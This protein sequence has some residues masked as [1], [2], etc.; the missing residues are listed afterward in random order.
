MTVQALVAACCVAA[1]AACLALAQESCAPRAAT[2]GALSASAGSATA[3]LRGARSGELSITVWYPG[4]PAALERPVVIGSEQQPMFVAGTVA[5]GAAWE[6]GDARPLLVVSHGFGGSARQLT[7][8]GSALARQ[9]YVVAAVDHPGSNGNE[10]M[11]PEGVYAPWERARDLSRAID[12]LLAHPDV[13]PRLDSQRI[14]VAGFSLGGWTA[15]LLAGARPDFDRL[16]AFC[17]GPARDN[18]CDPQHE[19][20]IDIFQQPQWLAQPHMRPLAAGAGASHRDPRVRGVLLIAPALGQALQPDSYADVLVPVMVVAGDRDT[21]TPTLSNAIEIARR[22]MQA[23]IEVLPHVGHY[24][25]LSLCTDHG[26][27]VAAA[28]CTDDPRSERAATHRHTVKL[29]AAF[30]ASL[31]G[32]SR[33]VG[34][35]SPQ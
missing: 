20:P 10:P 8:L 29:A 26:R 19:Y 33:A 24:D 13:G 5:Q 31:P 14:A 22:S 3:E 12:A 18:I 27:R 35:A 21:V 11:T 16:R 1:A 9:G 30:L 6:P 28:Y 2:A 17:T 15:M 23:R 7:W 25:F 34:W 4:D 32:W